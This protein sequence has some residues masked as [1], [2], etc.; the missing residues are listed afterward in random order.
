M[1]VDV[2]FVNFVL[3]FEIFDV[4]IIMNMIGD[5]FSDLGG[6]IMGSLGLGFSGNFCLEKDQFSM[7]EL[8]YGLVLDI[9]G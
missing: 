5:I 3:W 6:V 1:Y 2:V 7:F 9:V 8:I 4:V